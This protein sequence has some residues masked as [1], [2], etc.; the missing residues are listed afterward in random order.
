M[1]ES[2]TCLVVSG[3]VSMLFATGNFDEFPD[4][5]FHFIVYKVSVLCVVLTVQQTHVFLAIQFIV[6]M[7]YDKFT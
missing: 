1:I 3:C 7:G 4:E 5:A 6:M 2:Q